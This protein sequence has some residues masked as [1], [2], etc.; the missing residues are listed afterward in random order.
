M[1]QPGEVL[2]FVNQTAKFYTL[3]PEA[4]AGFWKGGGAGTSENLRRTK[5]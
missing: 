4:Y 5:I 2:C 3:K 1:A